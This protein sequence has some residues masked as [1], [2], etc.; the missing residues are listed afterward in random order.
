M[1]LFGISLV[2]EGVVAARE[3]FVFGLNVGERSKFG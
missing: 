2:D 3:F 1:R